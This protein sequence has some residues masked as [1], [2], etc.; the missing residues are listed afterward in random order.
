MDNELFEL[1]KE[2]Y[3]RTKW[4][5]NDLLHRLG[6]EVFYR[7]LFDSDVDEKH[8][9]E[10]YY[11]LYTSDYILEKL[12]KFVEGEK[13]SSHL[14]CL[15]PNPIGAGFQAMYHLS[16]ARPTSTSQNTK[17]MH[18]A[19]TPLKALLKLTIALHE[20]GEL[21]TSSTREG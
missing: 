2:V 19:D 18:T 15:Q 5:G 14:L 4:D 3:K 6:D 1:C 8:P 9:R 7:E 20:G 10:S 12:P 13:H 21:T 11:P 16:I 17:Y